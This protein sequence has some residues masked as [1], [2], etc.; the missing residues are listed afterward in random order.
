MSCLRDR[1]E[2]AQRLIADETPRRQLDRIV[3]LSEA[4]FG[5]PAMSPEGQV[6]PELSKLPYQLLAGAAGTLIEAAEHSADIAILAVHA[7]H[8]LLLDAE[9]VARNHRDFGVFVRALPGA[10]DLQVAEGQLVGPIRIA[11]GTG[12][13]PGTLLIGW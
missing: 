9:A 2:K 3:R 10:A 13:P 5:R 6:D 7:F 1:I 11:G 12:V 8:P 4:V